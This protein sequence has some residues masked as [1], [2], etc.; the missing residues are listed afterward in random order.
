MSSERA[1]KDLRHAVRKGDLA[2]VKKFV[3][4]G[5]YK[6]AISNPKVN[7]TLLFASAQVSSPCSA[8]TT[9][10]PP[11]GAPALSY[12][13]I[14]STFLLLAVRTRFH[15]RPPDRREG[16]RQHLPDLGSIP[17]V[18]CCVPGALFV[19]CDTATAAG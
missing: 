9:V 16:R 1:P 13:K 4:A 10:P 8:R 17:S 3:T 15:Y 18:Y 7:S 2:V 12:A 6:D 5:K 11:G 14:D 19:C